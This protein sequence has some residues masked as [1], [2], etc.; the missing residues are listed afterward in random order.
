MRNLFYN[1]FPYT[2]LNDINLDWIIKKVKT[3]S[4]EVEALDPEDFSERLDAVE[5]LANDASETATEAES[6]ASM[7][8]SAAN[9]AQ[10]AANN[11]Q[12]TASAAQTA[13]STAQTAA[14]NAQI[15]ANAA[16]TA[17]NNAQTTADSKTDISLGMTGT[18]AGNLVEIL[19]V[20]GNGKPTA[21]KEM[22]PVSIIGY[23]NILTYDST[24]VRIEG[25]SWQGWGHIARLT[26]AFR[27]LAAH[28]YND[29]PVFKPFTLIQAL[30]PPGNNALI[31]WQ[32][33]N[34]T[35]SLL[36]KTNGE[37]ECRADLNANELVQIA[38]IYYL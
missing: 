37:V 8:T 14:N 15:T 27:P 28:A 25:A 13:A 2:N 6:A 9:A 33:V 16:Q 34:K 1:R 12:S 18:S 21:Y 11:A 35:V 5:A 24:E 32:P 20:D 17:A 3:L 29:S 31:A 36:L 4:D 7:A 26:V 19:S 23:D 10:T 38:S 30:R 22:A